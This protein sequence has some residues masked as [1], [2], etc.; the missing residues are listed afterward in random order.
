MENLL[1]HLKELKLQVVMGYLIL[2]GLVPV[3]ISKLA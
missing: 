1:F 3:T 2:F